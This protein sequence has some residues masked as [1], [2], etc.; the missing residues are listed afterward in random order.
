MPG[1]VTEPV[2]RS[3]TESAASHSREGGAIAWQQ[4]FFALSHAVGHDIN[5]LLAGV[6]SL[7]EA[8][9]MQLAPEDPQHESLALIRARALRAG[10]LFGRLLQLQR[11]PSGKPAL[12]DLHQLVEDALE[13]LRKILPRAV[14]LEAELSGGPLPV[15]VDAVEF[16]RVFVGWL[17][18]LARAMPGGGALRVEI[19]AG[20]GAGVV[21]AADPARPAVPEYARAFMESYGGL[22]RVLPA[23][24]GLCALV[25]LPAADP[26]ADPA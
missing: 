2:H 13:L 11:A 23:A 4:A 8:G 9:R 16:R 21:V 6:V 24:R 12:A 3:S 14:T 15:R 20:A 10:E 26:D 19:R 1:A 17:A 5:N 7:A 25:S 22:I 18:Q